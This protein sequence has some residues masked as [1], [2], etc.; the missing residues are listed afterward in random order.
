MSK[1]KCTCT[2]CGG[3]FERYASVVKN[4]KT[5]FCDMNCKA[6][7]QKT[8]V[9]ELNPQYGREGKSGEDNP[10]YGNKWTEE[11]KEEARTRSL[12]QFNHSNPTTP[13][14]R[15]RTKST[16]KLSKEEWLERNRNRV[17]TEEGRRAIGDAAR[18][19]LTGISKPPMSEEQKRKIGIRSSEKF[20]EEYKAKYRKTM[21][22]RGYWI[23]LAEK[24]PYDLYFKKCDWIDRMFDIPQVLGSALLVEHGVFNMKTNTKGVVRDHR[25]GRKSG[26]T[27]KVFPE[28][29]RHPANCRIITH[30]NNVSKAQK[31]KSK[32]TDCEITLD[33]LFD[34]IENFMGEWK[35]H[36]EC[37]HLIKLY[38]Q[39][40]MYE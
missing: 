15:K 3:E 5:V 30:A 37:L 10:N 34:A 26:Y 24:D 22:D 9:G 18:K 17:W 11:Q 31:G 23:P 4:K 13:H 28:I 2:F 36:G 12:N 8:L 16:K 25:F 32:S 21:E 1:V 7:Y 39:G 40:N 29:M 33:E 38:R 19:R 20:T 35:E 27:M 14:A 6:E